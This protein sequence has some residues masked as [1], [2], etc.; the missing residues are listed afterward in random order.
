M[1]LAQLLEVIDGAEQVRIKEYNTQK[2]LY[3][4]QKADVF[5][6]EYGSKV[7][8]VYTTDGEFCIEISE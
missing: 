2:T 5:G 6:V 8:A 4:G 3:S 7:V 1:N